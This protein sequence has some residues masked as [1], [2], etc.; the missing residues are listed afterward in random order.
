MLMAVGS[1]E[2]DGPIRPAMSDGIGGGLLVHRRKLSSFFSVSILSSDGGLM[3]GMV[4]YLSGAIILP[5][6]V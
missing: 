4:P 3:V 6:L 1:S 2:V 5:A